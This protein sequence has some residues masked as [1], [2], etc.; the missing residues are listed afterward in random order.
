MDG[1]FARAMS[2]IANDPSTGATGSGGQVNSLGNNFHQQVQQ[3]LAI[4]LNLKTRQHANERVLR[5][6]LKSGGRCGTLKQAVQARAAIYDE[7]MDPA[8][9]VKGKNISEKAKT[10]EGR[11][12][13]RSQLIGAPLVVAQTG[14]QSVIGLLSGGDDRVVDT[15]HLGDRL[16][17]AEVLKAL[18]EATPFTVMKLLN[19]EKGDHLVSKLGQ[20]LAELDFAQSVSDLVAVRDSLNPSLDAVAEAFK[21]RHLGGVFLKDTQ[22]LNLQAL[23]YGWDTNENDS[24]LLTPEMKSAKGKGSSTRLCYAYQSGVCRWPNC[25][26]QH[27]CVLCNKYGHGQWKCYTNIRKSNE[28]SPTGDSVLKTEKTRFTDKTVPPNPRYRRDRN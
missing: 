15:L 5:G 8:F 22:D 10:T 9:F 21:R 17:V 4:K 11:R 20:L 2:S 13:V 19:G 12:K 26:Y 1:K 7:V 23:M 6:L 27:R 18:S 28:K 3:A 14:L 24:D 16:T 25:L